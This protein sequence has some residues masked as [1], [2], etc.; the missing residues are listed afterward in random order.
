MSSFI[1]SFSMKKYL[2]KTLLYVLPVF[3]L[4]VGVNYIGDAAKLFHNDFEKKMV[5][6]LNNGQYVTN[7]VNYDERVFQR[8]LIVNMTDAPKVV[9]LGSSRLMQITE[10]FLGVETMNNCVSGATIEDLIAIYQMYKSKGL[11]P[12]KFIVGIDPWVFNINNNQSRWLS[13]KNEY[14]EYLDGD[15]SR[16]Y[17]F[18]IL[19][20]Y[21]QL[22]SLSYFQA[23]VKVI[24]K[25]F[26]GSDLPMG[27][28]SINNV[29][30]T[31]LKD[32]SI[33]YSE[34][35]RNSTLEQINQR[36]DSYIKDEIYGLQDFEELS[37]LTTS[38]VKIFLKE[39][40]D[41]QSE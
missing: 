21:E 27:T 26:K 10:E 39:I 29:L 34:V 1:S 36:V 30:S 17:G 22:L 38:I 25:A 32:G 5:N 35:I 37:P 14:E 19:R 3:S 31:K 40:V 20:K 12:S 41:S 2:I 18:E 33:V 7:I 13:V 16:K 6:I 4:L 8:E 15:S 11:I 28:D 9:V 23:S 24:D